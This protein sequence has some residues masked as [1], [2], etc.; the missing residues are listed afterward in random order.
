MVVTQVNEVRI[1]R[2]LGKRKT[3]Y[4]GNFPQ[5][6][7]FLSRVF[8]KH[9]K[10]NGIDN[11]FQ[12]SFIFKNILGTSKNKS[13]LVLFKTSVRCWVNFTDQVKKWRK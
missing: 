2:S 3:V 6:W 7:S 12:H 4:S 13:G 11:L 1:E 8:P 10:F 5:D 9:S